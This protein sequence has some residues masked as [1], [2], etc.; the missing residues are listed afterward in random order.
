MTMCKLD[1]QAWAIT[2][3]IVSGVLALA[4]MTLIGIN[5]AAFMAAASYLV[6]ADLTGVARPITA[7]SFITG[8]VFWTV[9]PAAVAA[10]FA[11]IHNR[12]LPT[13]AGRVSHVWAPEKERVGSRRE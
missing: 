2:T 4:C 9:V 1:W 7:G 8:L 13:A 3:G 12:L 11:A 5:A 6:H 10:A